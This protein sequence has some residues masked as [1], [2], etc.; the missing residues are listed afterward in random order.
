MVFHCI[1]PPAILR[2]KNETRSGTITNQKVP[3]SEHQPSQSGSE[4]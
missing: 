3:S 1:Y 4:A 2:N